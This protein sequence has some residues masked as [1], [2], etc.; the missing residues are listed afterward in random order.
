[1]SV[2]LL[3]LVNSSLTRE[4]A[5]K[6]ASLLGEVSSSVSG[7][8]ATASASVMAG[9]INKASTTGGGLDLLTKINAGGFNGDFLHRFGS[10]LSEEEHRKGDLQKTGGELISWLFGPRQDALHKLLASSTGLSKSSVPPL[11]GMI[12]PLVMSVIGKQVASE[13]LDSK[14]LVNLLNTQK[15]AVQHSAPAALAPLLGLANLSL[16]GS[17]S[18]DGSGGIVQTIVSFIK[19]F[20]PFII[21]ILVIGL[22]MKTCS[23]QPARQ[24]PPP[25]PPAAV[26]PQA[27]QPLPDTTKAARDTTAVTADSLGTFGEYKL[28]NGV[29]LNIPEFGI[30]RKLIA[31]I[32]DK[33][34][35]VDKTTWFTFD[36]LIFDTGKATLKPV[37]QEQINNIGEILKAFPAVELKFGGYTDN[38]GDPKANLKLSQARAGTV[39]QEIVKLGIDKKRVAAEGYGDQHPVAD[40]ATGEGRQKNR[41]VDC[42]VTRK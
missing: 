38:V 21:G 26:A 27:P 4:D 16:L 32:E 18:Q 12:A 20:W 19:E 37:S 22:L 2:N 8:I 42:R 25:P 35:A 41:R 24:T 39:M 15:N 6:I 34:K 11:L 23:Q 9:L 13:N 1:M 40:N 5:G 31:F 36:R 29:K 17:T 3:E 14:G 28:P 7:G 30:E 10:M 33:T